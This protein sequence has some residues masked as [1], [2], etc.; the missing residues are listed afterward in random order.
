MVA[1]SA[2]AEFAQVYNTNSKSENCRYLEPT[3]FGQSTIFRKEQP[4][5]T[6][7]DVCWL[8]EIASTLLSFK[9]D[10]Y[11]TYYPGAK[12]GSKHALNK[13][14]A[15]INPC[16]RY[17]YLLSVADIAASLS[18]GVQMGEITVPADSIYDSSHP[19]TLQ[20]IVWQIHQC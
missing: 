7:L 17:A 18:R 12:P 10:Y 6:S 11:C 15:L 2:D 20:L 5:G 13:Q 14:Y 9:L 3:S 16:I 19:M 8:L 4:M 1:K